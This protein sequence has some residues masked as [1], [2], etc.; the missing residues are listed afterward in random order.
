MTNHF[1]AAMYLG[2]LA[3]SPSFAADLYRCDWADGRVMYQDSQCAIGVNQRA[4]DSQ[5]AKREQIRKT[6]EQERQ[7]KQRNSAARTTAG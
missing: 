4:I 2:F 3:C 1:R 6:L 5:N 7:R